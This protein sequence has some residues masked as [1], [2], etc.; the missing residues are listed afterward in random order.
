MGQPPIFY[1]T[2]DII[3]EYPQIPFMIPLYRFTVHQSIVVIDKIDQ[4]LDV[5]LFA[6]D[7]YDIQSGSQNLFESSITI[8]LRHRIVAFRDERMFESPFQLLL[9]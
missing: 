5:A 4:E 9:N 3:K 7:K 2:G 6:R 8:H 1:Y